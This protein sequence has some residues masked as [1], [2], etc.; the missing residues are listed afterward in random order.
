M[1]DEGADPSSVLE[2]V[3]LARTFIE[4]LDPYTRIEER[5]LAKSLGE[6]VVV[7]CDIREG[8]GARTK[9]NDGTAPCCLPYDLQFGFGITVAINLPVS[10]TVAMNG[11]LEA[12]G[13]SVDN[14]DA[15][16]WRPP[17]TLYELSSNLPP[18]CSIVMMISAA[19]RP[20]PRG[21]R[22]VSRARCR[23]P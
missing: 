8:I 6:D 22:P 19:G 23:R 12:L 21:C 2:D 1:L 10:T 4:Q 13:Q 5:Q 18:A 14:G 9:V 3:L 20:P 15:T 11:E 17:E 7:K 16:P